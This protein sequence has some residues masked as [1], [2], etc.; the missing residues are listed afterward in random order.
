MSF[1]SLIIKN[2][3]RSKSR[4]LLSIIGIGMGIATIVALGAITDGLIAS[5]EDTLHAGG[6]DFTI[7]SKEQDASNMASFGTASFNETWRD[8]IAN[9]TGI[10][11][12]AGVYVGMAIT[13]DDPIFILI[14]LDK[15]YY[16]MIDLKITEGSINKNDNEIIIGKMAANSINKTVG[17]EISLNGE[18]YKITGVF[19]TGNPNMDMGGITSLSTVQ[20]L[21]DDEGQITSI[22]VKVDQDQDV[23]AISEKIDKKYEDNLTTVTSLSDI[24]MVGEMV[25]MLNGASL[26]ISVLA[27][28]IGG[29]GIINTMLMSV[30]ERIR[31]IGVLKAVGWSNK[32]ILFMIIGE[33]IVITIT[34]GIIGSV[35][36][37]IGVELLTYFQ[38]MP[39]VLPVYTIWTF[40][41]AFIVALTVGIIG[42][43]YPAIKA[44]NLPPTEALRYE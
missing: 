42:G 15:E 21:M 36:G 20:D 8:K 40:A 11:W 19:E 29:V 25:D 12:A 33:S 41:K 3:F 17:D 31:E 35:V 23:D 27:I 10:E 2:P 39:G 4:A 24:E 13:D 7:S 38:V 34:A 22:Y 6:S 32:R 9:E 43:I 28:V 18:N 16:D 5:A 30:F 14:G 37:V 26:A 1:L 44:T